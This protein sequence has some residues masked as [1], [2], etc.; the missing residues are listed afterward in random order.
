MEEISKHRIDIE[1]AVQRQQGDLH[2]TKPWYWESS[3]NGGK[4]DWRKIKN[5]NNK[6]DDTTPPDTK[7]VG[8]PTPQQIAN[9][10]VRGKGKPM[11]TQKLLVW[12]TK[13]D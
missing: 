12:V 13:T 2:P 7:K 9:A 4:G 8:K 5:T 10:K 1:K 11:D 3:A 6:K